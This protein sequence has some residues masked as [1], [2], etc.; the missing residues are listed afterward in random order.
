[1][2]IDANAH[3]FPHFAGASGYRDARTHLAMQQSKLHTWW[4]R[5]V[6]NTMEEQYMP[7]PERKWTSG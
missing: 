6:S 2:I 1:M 7:L 3:A 5:M 4:G